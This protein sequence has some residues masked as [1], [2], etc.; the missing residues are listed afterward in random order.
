MSTDDVL[1]D[2][3]DLAVGKKMRDLWHDSFTSWWAS[4]SPCGDL[5]GVNRQSQVGTDGMDSGVGPG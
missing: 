1:S 2:D 4:V 3:E 5:G